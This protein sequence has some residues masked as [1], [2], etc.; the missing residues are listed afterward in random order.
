MILFKRVGSAFKGI[1]GREWALLSLETLGVVA[2]I[3]IAFQLNEW[4]ANWNEAARRHLLM[5]RLFE[6]TQWDVTTLRQM[7]DA[8]AGMS[9]R[10]GQF[11]TEI[12]A[13]RCPAAD[14]WSANETVTMMPSL[15]A[16]TAVYQEMMGAGGLASIDDVRIREQVSLFHGVLE[17]SQHQNDY[18]RLLKLITIEPGDPRATRSYIESADEPEVV[19]YD[20][21]ALCADKSYRNRVVDAVRN[22]AVVTSYHVDTT[23]EAI[24]ACAMLGEYLGRDCRPFVG[25]PLTG[26]DAKAASVAATKLQK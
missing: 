19:E 15:T 16:P 23:K 21:Q 10:E 4:A 2:G 7:R 14:L 22:H 9:K 25:G 12:S 1:E 18:F 26:D 5:E 8:M 17:W 13:G 3:L 20:R 24:R 6:E 11:A